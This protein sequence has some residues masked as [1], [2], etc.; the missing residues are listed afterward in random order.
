MARDYL[1]RVQACGG[2]QLGAVGG[3]GTS[4]DILIYGLL[5]HEWLGSAMPAGQHVTDGR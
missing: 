1:H 5:R 3:D 4:D 2:V